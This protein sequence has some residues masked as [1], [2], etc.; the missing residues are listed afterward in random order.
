MKR[1]KLLTLGGGAV[2]L[3]AVV[4]LGL[5]FAVFKGGEERSAAPEGKSIAGLVQQE[6]IGTEAGAVRGPGPDSVGA[7]PERRG[8]AP[9]EGIQVHGH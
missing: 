6:S 5:Y 8:G 2:V 1:L 7:S 4:A 3:G 9:I